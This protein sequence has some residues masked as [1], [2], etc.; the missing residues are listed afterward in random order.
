MTGWKAWLLPPA[1]VL[2][3]APA[4]A[5][6][7]MTVAAAQGLAFPAA[8]R[9]QPANVVYTPPQVA[10]IETRSGQPVRTKGEQVWRAL[11]GEPLLGFFIVDY[12]IGKHLVID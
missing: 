12:V 8:T 9:F 10:A 11:A 7:Y 1:I 2:A 5:T 4:H 3:A 6:Q